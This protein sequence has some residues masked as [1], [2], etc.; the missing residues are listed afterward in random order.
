VENRWHTLT[1]STKLLRMEVLVFVTN[2]N[3]TIEA[4]KILEELRMEAD[5]KRITFDLEDVDRV[6]RVE[7]K[8][9]AYR[10]WI[11]KNIRAMGY[12]CEEMKDE[13]LPL[14]TESK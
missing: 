8:S 14:F 1:M 5:F 10:D 2:V 4:E 3:S 9:D 7:A 6:L 13:L 12:D 11:Q